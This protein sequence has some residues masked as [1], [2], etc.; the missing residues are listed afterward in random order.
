[1][2]NTSAKLHLLNIEK[3]TKAIL[4]F[5]TCELD[6]NNIVVSGNIP[7]ASSLIQTQNVSTIHT[8]YLPNRTLARN[9]I[10]GM[11]IL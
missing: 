3:Y 4:F 1:M 2:K 5:T 6:N 9:V 8:F 11:N 10:F 7:E